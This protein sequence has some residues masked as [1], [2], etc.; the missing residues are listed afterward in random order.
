MPVVPG[1]PV[2]YI[3]PDREAHSGFAAAPEQENLSGRMPIRAGWKPALPYGDFPRTSALGLGDNEHLGPPG[4][5]ARPD[6]PNLAG[7]IEAID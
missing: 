3:I 6:D 2:G 7:I 5:A 4:K 1:I